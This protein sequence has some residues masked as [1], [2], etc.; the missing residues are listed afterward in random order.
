[1]SVKSLRSLLVAPLAVLLAGCHMVLLNPAGDVARQESDLMIASVVLC[2]IIIVPVLI[3]IGVI[4]YRYRAS[5]TDRT[6]EPD[7]DHSASLELLI[8]AAPLL[9]II[10]LGAMTWIGTH[11]LDPYR[12]LGRVS[13]KQPISKDVKPLHVDVVSME[14]KW[15]FFYPQYG[16]ATVNQL[17]AP[18]NVP[19]DFDITSQT[20]MDGFFIP[21]LAGQ[22]YSMPGMQ[23]QMHAVINKPGNYRGFS[24]NYSGHGFTDMRFRFLG[25]TAANFKKWVEKVKSTGKPLSNAAYTQLSKPTRAEPVHYYSSYVAGLY[26]RILNR[27][28]NPGQMCISEMMALDAKGGVPLKHK[29]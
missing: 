28:V 5:R 25:M 27:C 3:A 6:Y 18:V 15:L 26:N 4:A 16:I 7:W 2:C 8:W 20:M 9:I 22:V 13:S 24:A 1:M 19:I 23:T 17:A 10:A 21:T 14:W 12:S 29:D 11:T